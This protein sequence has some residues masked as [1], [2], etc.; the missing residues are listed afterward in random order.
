[1]TTL[2]LARAHRRARR[3]R[4][5][6]SRTRSAAPSRSPTTPSRVRRSTSTS[7]SS[8]RPTSSPTVAAPLL[9]LGASAD[10]PQ[11]V[12]AIRQ[13]GQARVMW[14]STPLD[15][16]FAYD[17]FHDA[18]AARRRDGPVRRHPDPHPGGRAPRRV[19][20][21]LR[22]PEGLGRHRRDRRGRNARRHRPR[23][24]GGSDASPVTTIRA[25]TAS[26]PFSHSSI[27]TRCGRLRS[28]DDEDGS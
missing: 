18:A 15:L 16:F 26:P 17:V 4:S 9:A 3:A 27:E 14:D 23:C 8:S 13:D 28:A 12:D 22:S 25:T 5:T 1:M 10:D 19:Q 20:G 7:I 21:R 24:C 11:V 6:P 2:T